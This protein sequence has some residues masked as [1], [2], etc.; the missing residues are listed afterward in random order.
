[1]KP[2]MK[3][4]SFG[5]WVDQIKPQKKILDSLSVKVVKNISKLKGEPVWMLK[6]RLEALKIF[7]KISLPKWG[8]DLTKLN[9]GK[10]HY[11]SRS[12]GVAENDWQKV[13]GKIKKTFDRLGVPKLEAEFL[14]GAGA[15]YDS[16]MVY[17]SL[18]KD[19]K[20]QG[21]IFL[22]LEQAISKY[23][24]L[25][26]KYFGQVVPTKD[27]KLAALNSAVWSGGS[28][29]YVPPKVKVKR[30]LHAYFRLNARGL[31]Q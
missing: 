17:H 19:L 30:P 21:V 3:S 16:E 7:K 11:Y 1:M 14:G 8:P 29:I 15:Q 25:V 9:F 12:A 4:I 5:Q 27:N 10:I 31:G 28:F 26:K 2:K 13:P 6:R 22:S 24:K 18:D 20:A 23:P